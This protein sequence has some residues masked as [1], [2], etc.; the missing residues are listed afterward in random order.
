MCRKGDLGRIVRKNGPYAESDA[1][2][3]F[4]QIVAAIEYLHGLDVAHRDL[5]PENVLLNHQDRVKVADFGL[6]NFCR[7]TTNNSRVLLYTRCGTRTYMPPEV[8]NIAG[9]YNAMFFD[10]WSMGE[11]YFFHPP[12]AH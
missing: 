7:D 11:C 8:L 5:K 1:R 9:G 12:T 2:P 4:S 10:I 3:L 6:A